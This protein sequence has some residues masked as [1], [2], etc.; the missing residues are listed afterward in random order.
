MGQGRIPMAIPEV[1][2]GE[3]YRLSAP[4]FMDV[5]VTVK[6]LSEEAGV[7]GATETGDEL[8]L[9]LIAFLRDAE[10]KGAARMVWKEAP[11]RAVPK[12]PPPEPEAPTAKPAKAPGRRKKAP[13]APEAPPP[14]PAPAAE[15]AFP[16]PAK[17]AVSEPFSIAEQPG[18]FVVTEFGTL[19]QNVK[20]KE[21]TVGVFNSKTG[22]WVTHRAPRKPL[23]GTPYWTGAQN[24]HKSL[25]EVNE[26]LAGKA[27][28]TA[29]EAAPPAG[30]TLE[31]VPA[32]T[33]QQA[34][35]RARKMS[36]ESLEAAIASQ[37]ATSW[38]RQIAQEEL[39]RRAQEVAGVAAAARP[40]AAAPDERTLEQIESSE[41]ARFIQAAGPIVSQNLKKILTDTTRPLSLIHI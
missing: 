3:T 12:P 30:R 41:L 15:P 2:V 31:Q 4:P 39:A 29:P 37:R 35:E 5:E 24:I 32:I 19:V 21:E 14:Q 27:T 23:E 33:A 25:L 6:E 7:V 13:E 9:P 28:Y 18:T 8:R 1:V 17:T 10:P 34:R 40:E 22:R 36:R 11:S 20:G 16:P 38:Q 26:Y